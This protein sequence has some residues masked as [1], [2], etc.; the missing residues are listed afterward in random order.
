MRRWSSRAK[1][2]AAA[3]RQT[4]AG[5]LAAIILVVWTITAPSLAEAANTPWHK[6]ANSRLRLIAAQVGEGGK[7]ALMAGLDMQLD[8]GWTTY[9][10]NPG[11]SG[12]PPSFDWSGSQNV[13]QV[14]VL[15]PAPRAYDEAG[16]VAFGYQGEVVFPVRIVPKDPAKPV[17]LHLKINYALCKNLCVPNRAEL[18]LNVASD[19]AKDPADALL[20]EQY[21]AWV[22]KPVAAGVLP[23]L[24]KVTP[25]LDQPK[26]TLFIDTRFPK[27]EG[28]TELYL[29]NPDAYVPAASPVGLLPNGDLR[30]VVRFGNKGEVEALKGKTVSLILVDSQGAR[31]ATWRLK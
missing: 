6:E 24:V 22:P 26:P 5:S 30:F 18:A 23:A 29:A 20:L 17:R 13:R 21:L 14:E 3:W 12:V 31:E 15:Y 10:R 16:G 2:A 19:E 25:K 11:D 28:R 1:Q 7:Q 27:G 9:W 8:P 4:A